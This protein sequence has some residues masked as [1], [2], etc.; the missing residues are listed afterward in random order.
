[1]NDNYELCNELKAEQSFPPRLPEINTLESLSS[2]KN[3]S[4]EGAW[5]IMF[6]TAM[7]CINHAALRDPV[8]NLFLNEF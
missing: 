7:S 4:H 1:M 3:P 6:Q 5:W 2:S 8:N